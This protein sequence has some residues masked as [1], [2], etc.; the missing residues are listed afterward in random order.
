M[1]TA[2]VSMIVMLA[3]AGLPANYKED[4]IAGDDD[5]DDEDEEDVRLQIECE[6]ELGIENNGSIA[7]E[8]LR[9]LR[10]LY[11]KKQAAKTQEAA[12]KAERLARGEVID[13]AYGS[14]GPE[15]SIKK[16]FVPKNL[17]SAICAPGG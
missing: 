6:A 13:E 2:N 11:I 10:E 16:A 14:D 8:D 4:C 7:V 3:R 12:D 5:D 17:V 1:T 15:E 9:R